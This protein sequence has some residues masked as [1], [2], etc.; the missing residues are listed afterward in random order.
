M[1]FNQGKWKTFF[2]L[3]HAIQ[4]LGNIFPW[5]SSNWIPTCLQWTVQCF[6]GPRHYCCCHKW[7]NLH[8]FSP[9][10]VL[11]CF[12]EERNDSVLL[13][14]HI[15]FGLDWTQ[16][17]SPFPPETTFEEKN[18][19]STKHRKRI[20][21]TEIVQSILLSE[22]LN[23]NAKKQRINVKIMGI[24]SLSYVCYFIRFNNLRL[25]CP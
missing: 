24:D 1:L 9:L 5:Q 17:M 15:S 2:S 8:L 7:L 20:H 22:L 18:S 19:L 12:K 14:Y 25:R 10:F 13:Q 23:N 4:S 6:Y 16:K 21:E 11:S 3:I